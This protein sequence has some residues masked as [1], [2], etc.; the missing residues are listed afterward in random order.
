MAELCSLTCGSFTG[1]DPSSYREKENA[2]Q[3]IFHFLHLDPENKSLSICGGRDV[4]HD[5][6]RL[7]YIFNLLASILEEEGRG[8]ILL[9]CDQTEICY[10]RRNRWKLVQI[11]IPEDPFEDIHYVTEDST[12]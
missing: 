9:T 3:E 2:L 5:P 6:E 10:F 4:P 7:K 12:G 8:S 11:Y 1:V